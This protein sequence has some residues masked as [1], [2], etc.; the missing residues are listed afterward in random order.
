MCFWLPFSNLLAFLVLFST[1]AKAQ[2]NAPL[3]LLPR[4]ED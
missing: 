3:R 4:I 2:E 1:I